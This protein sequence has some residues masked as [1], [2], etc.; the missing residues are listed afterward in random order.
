MSFEF[1][2]MLHCSISIDSLLVSALSQVKSTEELR[3]ACEA[4]GDLSSFSKLKNEGCI[5]G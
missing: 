5:L 4:F 3:V 1:T 2:R